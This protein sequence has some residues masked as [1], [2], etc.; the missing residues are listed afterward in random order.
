LSDAEGHKVGVCLPAV[1]GPAEWRFGIVNAGECVV[2][3]TNGVH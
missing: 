1:V 3:I 2:S